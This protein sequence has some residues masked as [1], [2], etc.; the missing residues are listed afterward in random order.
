[1]RGGCA[2]IH[3][4]ETEEEARISN[5]VK[6]KNK[7]KITEVKVN[8]KLWAII[9]GIFIAAIVGLSIWAS[10]HWGVGMGTIGVRPV[11]PED[12]AAG[13]TEAAVEYATDGDVVTLTPEEL[14]EMGIS[15]D[16]LQEVTP[17]EGEAATEGAAK[18]AGEG[19]AAEAEA[20]S[21]AQDA[22]SAQ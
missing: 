14:E 21:D 5:T 17:E 19:E 4:R 1:M 6:I 3:K 13:A 12:A 10:F 7:K 18:E 20:E 15:V 16:G 9:F 11:N 8:Y 2:E 22:E